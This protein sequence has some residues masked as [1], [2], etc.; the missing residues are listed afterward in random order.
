MW[1]RRLLYMRSG[2]NEEELVTEMRRQ[3]ESATTQGARRAA[4]LAYRKLRRSRRQNFSQIQFGLEDLRRS[5]KRRGVLKMKSATGE[6]ST[7][8]ED[9]LRWKTD[10]VMGFLALRL[11][12]VVV[13]RTQ[14]Y[15]H[16]R[17]I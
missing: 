13:A 16:Q 7:S 9:W 12:N 10:H 8:P 5:R 15:L 1:I 17:P 4:R 14:G 11:L 3:W 6:T 2:T